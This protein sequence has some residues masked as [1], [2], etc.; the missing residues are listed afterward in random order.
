MPSKMQKP[1]IDTLCHK[2]S[3]GIYKETNDTG[4]WWLECN[5]CGS[6]LFCYNPMPHQADFHDDE[7][8]FKAF[9]GGYG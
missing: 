8:K 9:F 5:E 4:D 3:F 1:F 6:M 7:H 2:C